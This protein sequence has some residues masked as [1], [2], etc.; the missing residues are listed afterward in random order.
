MELELF[1][2]YEDQLVFVWDQ[3]N[4]TNLWPQRSQVAQE[5]PLFL[6]E[7]SR[8]FE[9]FP[10]FSAENTVLLD[11]HLEKFQCNPPNTCCLVPEF[12]DQ[13]HQT[14]DL[15]APQG[16]FTS[17]LRSIAEQYPGVST[18]A[19]ISAL[20]SPLFP[21]SYE[22]VVKHVDYALFETIEGNLSVVSHP[23][24]GSFW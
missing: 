22:Q 3:E 1:E 6:K 12:N 15:L 19:A 17:L 23:C 9:A 10:Q 18:S 20:D 8:V 5:K 7:L 11:N 16:A 2:A 21:K 14:D 4:S 13:Q 24:I